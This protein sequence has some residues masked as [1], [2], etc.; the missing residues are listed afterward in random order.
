MAPRQP[1]I[2]FDEKSAPKVSKLLRIAEWMRGRP[3]KFGPAPAISAIGIKFALGSCMPPEFA[4]HSPHSSAS[5][6]LAL[7]IVWSAREPHR[8]GEVALCPSEGQLWILGRHPQSHAR[9]KNLRMQGIPMSF[10]RQRPAGALDRGSPVDSAALIAGDGISRRQL[11]IQVRKDALLVKNIGRCPLRINGI[12]VSQ[13]LVRP[14]DTIHLRNQLILYCCWRPLEL[15]PLQVYPAERAPRF[16][17]PDQDG[18]IGE[19]PAIWALRERL[20]RLAATHQ[21]V[22]VKSA[23]KLAREQAERALT[24]LQSTF[25]AAAVARS[26]PAQGRASIGIMPGQRHQA[27]GGLAQSI[28]APTTGMGVAVTEPG[29]QEVEVPDLN[30]RPEDIPLILYHLLREHAQ[31]AAHDLSPY[32]WMGLPRLHPSLIETLLHQFYTRH[33]AEVVELVQHAIRRAASGNNIESRP[34]SR[35]SQPKP[36]A[37]GEEPAKQRSPAPWASFA[38]PQPATRRPRTALPPP[39]LATNEGLR[40]STRAMLL[41]EGLSIPHEWPPQPGNHRNRG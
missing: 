10:A 13:A 37:A 22:G 14:R 35:R 36:T 8:V 7:V 29:F 5:R 41:R 18:L 15:P 9:G 6:V 4:S 3:L 38:G 16:G 27:A 20:A 1:S 32:F 12:A 40:A 21:P 2:F 33:I 25:A 19:S 24:A 28:I 26:L 39:Q 17:E 31:D 23:C 34:V 30:E 11:E